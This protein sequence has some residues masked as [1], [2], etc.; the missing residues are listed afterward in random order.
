MSLY[1]LC[2]YSELFFHG[3]VQGSEPLFDVVHQCEWD[4]AVGLTM[5][6]QV[7]PVRRLEQPS[8]FIQWVLASRK[9]KSSHLLLCGIQVRVVLSQPGVHEG[10][11]LITASR[12]CGG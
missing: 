8:E 4:L 10:P 3:H 11:K 1:V 2:G 7:I 5:S 6:C 9:L 12:L